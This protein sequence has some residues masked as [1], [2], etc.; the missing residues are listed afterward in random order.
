[1]KYLLLIFFLVFLPRESFPQAAM[2]YLADDSSHA[3]G[4]NDE[5][6]IPGS[7]SGF[8]ISDIEIISGKEN[9]DQK[10][11]SLASDSK[12]FDKIVIP[13]SEWQELRIFPYYK[14][15]YFLL[16][17]M[18]SEFLPLDI[19]IF[20][21]NGIEKN[22]NFSQICSYLYKISWQEELPDG[23]YLCRVFGNNQIK[24]FLID[25]PK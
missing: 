6:H 18:G 13:E 17:A 25:I 8:Y 12:Y 23:D 11:G 24:S 4:M 10:T 21:E 3:S 15:N 22:V 9:T 16:D 14:Q 2:T 19:K 7:Y 1:M 20:D 5:F